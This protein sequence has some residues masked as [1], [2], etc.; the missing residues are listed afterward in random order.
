[1]LESQ[2]ALFALPDGLSYLDCAY[3]S[4]IPKAAIEAGARGA[5]V[6]AAPWTMTIHSYYDE[7]EEAR[8]LAAAVIGAA[9]GDV[10]VIGAT[11]YGMAT[12]AKNVV[13][14]PD[15]VIVMME[16]EHPSHR[17]VWYELAADRGA[18]VQVVPKPADGDW[19]RAMIDAIAGAAG[20]VAVVAG[21]LLHWFEGAAVDIRAL[22]A[23]T[24]AAGAALVVDGTQWVGAV[25]FEVTEIQPDF[26]SFAT[27]KFLLGPYRLAFLYASDRWQAE[28]RPL[29][30]HAWHRING[31]APDFYVETV[32]GF[33]PGAR[34]FDMGQRS[35]FAVLPV[36][37]ESLKLIDRL[38]VPAIH[39]RIAMLN[40][41]VWR[42]ALDCGLVDRIDPRRVP[43]IAILD[44]NGRLR[45]G[46]G[47]ALRSAGVHVTMRGS[48]MRVS[49][50]VYNEE[51]DIDR[52]FAVLS[53]HAAG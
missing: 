20:P 17:Y 49:P 29:E 1:M 27:Y 51:A 3:M 32:P 31:D 5:A 28:G 47:A 36:A 25:P 38:G 6:K 19:T 10:A 21:T 13:V 2:R 4:P 50:H 35:D 33:K 22:A 34:R 14:A 24:R 11:S 44:M 26:L 7:A 42:K 12:A 9:P 41:R 40:D 53:A 15:S 30:H 23:A 16:N 18:R 43:H 45:D 8:S 48:K 52:L 39:Q 37:I 46:V